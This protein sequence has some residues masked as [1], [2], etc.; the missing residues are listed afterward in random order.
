MLCEDSLCG[1]GDVSKDTI[2]AG[3]NIWPVDLD[4]TSDETD[5]G[6]PAEPTGMLLR[7]DD[8]DLRVGV[9]QIDWK[10]DKLFK[11]ADPPGMVPSSHEVLEGLLRDVMTGLEGFCGVVF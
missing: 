3:V 1:L 6:E 7:G 2:P 4:V 11:E 10:L 5:L 8:V 9:C